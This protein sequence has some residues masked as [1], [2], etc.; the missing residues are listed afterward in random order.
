MTD[1]P[2][3]DTEKAYKTALRKRG[4]FVYRD[5]ETGRLVTNLYAQE[6][7]GLAKDLGME[8]EIVESNGP[9]V[10]AAAVEGAVFPITN[11]C[12]LQ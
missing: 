10:K 6:V 3:T 11:R 2:K 7:P 9:I 4:W 5:V 12:E 1:R 8:L